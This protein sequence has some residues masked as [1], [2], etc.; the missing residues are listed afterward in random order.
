MKTC[1]KCKTEKP[2]SDF[3]TDRSKKHCLLARCKPCRQKQNKLWRQSKPGYEKRRYKKEKNAVR[4]RH[5]KRK[6]K[7][8]LADYAVML[9]AQAGACAICKAPEPQHKMLDVDHC[10]K[11]GAV[12]GLLCTNCNRMLG[13]SGDVPERLRRAADYLEKSPSR[14]SKKSGN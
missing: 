13:H 9:L 10:H 2:I 12:R 6:Y 3:G 7:I 5:L 8:T 1:T 14:S 4:E 11:T